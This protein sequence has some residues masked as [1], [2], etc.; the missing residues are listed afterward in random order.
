MQRQEIGMDLVEVVP[1]LQTFYSEAPALLRSLPTSYDR[2]VDMPFTGNLTIAVSD[3]VKE[4]EKAADGVD[5]WP[6]L[7]LW[8]NSYKI[9]AGFGRYMQLY[10]DATADGEAKDL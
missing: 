9:E 3:K 2:K 4:V 7:D 6:L 5:V 8:A 10:Y 1:Y